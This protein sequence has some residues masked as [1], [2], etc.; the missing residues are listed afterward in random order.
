MHSSSRRHRAS[1]VAGSLSDEPHG[2][3]IPSI[4]VV[5]AGDHPVVNIRLVADPLPPV[6]IVIK[7]FMRP[8]CLR[9]LVELVERVQVLLDD[10]P[11]L[12]LG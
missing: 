2:R 3:W 1:R 12:A 9:R 6:D 5:A 10:V 11:V 4:R 8:A 7:T